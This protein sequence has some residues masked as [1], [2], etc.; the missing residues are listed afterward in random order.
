MSNES[1]ELINIQRIIRLK[2]GYLK[3]CSFLEFK[4]QT[5]EKERSDFYNELFRFSLDHLRENGFTYTIDKYDKV[6][7]PKGISLSTEMS[8]DLD[9]SYNFFSFFFRKK[10]KRKLYIGE[11]VELILYI[12]AQ[13]F[14]KENERNLLNIN[15]GIKA[16]D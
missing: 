6:R 13:N 16:V 9:A 4:A 5:M 8:E 14:L 7:K 10:Y 2:D 1:I 3:L 11:F 12:Y 15:Y